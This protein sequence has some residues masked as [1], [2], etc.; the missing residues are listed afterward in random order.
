MLKFLEAVLI[1]SGMIIGVGMF[2]IPFS[3]AEAGFWL[4]T[5]ELLLL[6][7]IVTALHLLYAEVV[8]HTQ[9]IHRMPGYVRL[10]LGPRAALVA[11]GSALFGILG[12]LLAY[13]LVGA[14]FLNGIFKY[15]YPDTTESFWA[16]VFVAIAAVVTFFPLRRAALIN[17]VLT[18]FLIFFILLLVFLLSPR[19]QFISLACSFIY[20][21]A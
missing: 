21:F 12:A 20:I 14:V 5:L 10:Y 3:F 1:L 6:A 16:V 4:G 7:G 2:A 15:F 19:V 9:E 18:T 13:I 17:G 8:I 11:R